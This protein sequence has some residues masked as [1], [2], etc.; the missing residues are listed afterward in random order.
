MK[1]TVLINIGNSI[2]HITED[3]YEILTKY[4]HEIKMHFAKNIDDFE[5]VKDIEYRI[6]E[7]LTERLTLKEAQLIEMDDVEII[8]ERM[9]SVKDFERDEEENPTPEIGFTSSVKK[10]LFRDEESRVVGGVCAGLSYYLRIPK[11]WIRI[12]FI[13]MCFGMGLGILLYLI[14]WIAVPRAK[15][16]AEKMK[17][18]GES[19]DLH[20]F[21]KSFEE[22]LNLFKAKMNEHSHEINP[23]IEKSDSILRQLINGIGRILSAIFKLIGKLIGVFI[24]FFGGLYILSLLIGVAI[25]MGYWD[26][27]IYQ[28]FPFNVVNAEFRY[29]L[30][31][32]AFVLLLIPVLGL[33]LY[34]I[35]VMFN[36][37]PINNRLALGMLVVWLGALFVGG[38]YSAKL[39]SEFKETASIEQTISLTP[40]KLYVLDLNY[41]A[42]FRAIDSANYN[43]N[44]STFQNKKIVYRWY[45]MPNNM[46]RNV[47]LSIKSSDSQPAYVTQNFESQGKSFKQA[48]NNAKKLDYKFSQNGSQ[49]KFNAVAYLLPGQLY[50]DQ[51]V[52]ITLNIPV[53]AKLKIH[54]ELSNIMYFQYNCPE[55]GLRDGSYTYWE[56]TKEGLKCIE[57][58]SR[59]NNPAE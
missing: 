51:T 39:A 36:L 4:L 20:A 57:D 14:L 33:L 29:P 13:L 40:E 32:S 43:L 46:D 5:I 48:L 38:M 24:I 12:A 44:E 30:I 27:E 16:R 56:M 47:R 42:D 7:M 49:I 15:T 59:S 55:E 18:R 10:E 54:D 3:A 9:G 11:I 50:R 21:Q 34:A 53:G 8:M 1:K 37:K 58:K 25:L 52:R 2:L 28:Y 19:Q 17:M 23:I 45:N 6:A 31:L 41:E 22:E 26:A 35:R